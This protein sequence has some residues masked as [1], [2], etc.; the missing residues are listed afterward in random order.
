M[1]HGE[2]WFNLL[3]FFHSVEHAA[4]GLG[5]PFNDEGL[6]WY[7]GEHIGVQHVFGLAF[8]VL[9]LLIFGLITSAKIRNVKDAVV[10][11]DKLTIATFMELVVG[12]AYSMMSD[13]MGKKAAKFF[14]PLIGTC[15]LVILFGNLL[16]LV[17]GF[18]PPT[19]NLNT[20]LPMGL[21]IF[22]ATHIFGF[23]ENGAAYAKHFLGPMMAIAPLMFV[24]ELVSHAVRPASLAIRLMA[25]MTADHA[26]VDNVSGLVPWV[27][28]AAPLVLGTL[29]C[30]VQTL[31]FCLLSTVY[32][33]MAIAH[34]H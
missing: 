28:P 25:N 2:T 31:V 29:V 23:K 10:P 34:D 20:T 33:S 1:P 7:M 15:A 22:F 21:V 9:L 27:V 11:G 17:P 4:H 30:V 13:I 18:L 3:P 24:I 5:A 6:T 8:V 16:G 32:I 19:S 14:L 26:V 12:A